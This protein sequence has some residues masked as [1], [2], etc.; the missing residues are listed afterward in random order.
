M[1]HRNIRSDMRNA[2]SDLERFGA[3]VCEKR[4]WGLSR[5]TFDDYCSRTGTDPE[6]LDSMLFEELGMT[7][8]EVLESLGKENHHM[9]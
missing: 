2:T 6:M 8:E 3:Y 9:E 7:G 4:D 1:L 5:E